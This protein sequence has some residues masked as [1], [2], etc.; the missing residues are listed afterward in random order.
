MQLKQLHTLQAL[1]SVRDFLD[2]NELDVRMGPL[3]PHI[4]TLTSSIDRLESVI[5]EQEAKGKLS[6]AG[7]ALKKRLA[8][9]VLLELMRPI[10]R[11]APALF[12]NDEVLLTAL[13]M[14]R[15]RQPAAVL[16]AAIAMAD[17]AAAHVQEY[18]A[19]GL[20]PDFIERLRAGAGQL[21]LVTDTQTKDRGRRTASTEGTRDAVTQ[22]RRVVRLID[23]MV[24]PALESDREHLAEW[25]T[26]YRQVRQRTVVPAAESENPVGTPTP[27]EGAPGQQVPVLKAA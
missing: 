7:T 16:A 21:K 24:S 17:N 9:S 26:L 14:P 5:V 2:R 13:S 19:G 12:K 11:M 15:R 23:A 1:R 20:P 10:A 8:R 25:R 18:V 4:V 27:G 3:A 22:A 6:R